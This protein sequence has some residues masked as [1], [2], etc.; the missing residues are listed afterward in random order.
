MSKRRLAVAIRLSIVALVIIVIYHVDEVARA[1]GLA[2]FIPISNPM[3]RGFLFEFTAMLLAAAAFVISWKRPSIIVPM[4]L[5]VA[6]ALMVMDGIAIGTKYFTILTLPGPIL[7]LIY[8]LV[9]LALGVAKAI[10]A[11]IALK[12]PVT[13][14]KRE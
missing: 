13:P 1:S 11:T 9:V 6:G 5:I 3:Q 10:E 2:G 7:G 8:G 12:T 4:L 14:L